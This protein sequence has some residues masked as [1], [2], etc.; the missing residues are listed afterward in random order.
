LKLENI[1]LEKWTA[2]GGEAREA[3]GQKKRV[4][5]GEGELG[6]KIRGFRPFGNFRSHLDPY[7]AKLRPQGKF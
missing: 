2:G 7:Q 3:Q 6:L 1:C 5:M 4:K